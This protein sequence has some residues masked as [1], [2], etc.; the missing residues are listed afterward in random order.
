VIG[1]TFD[2]LMPRYWAGVTFLWDYYLSTRVHTL[3]EPPYVDA[4]RGAS[5]PTHAPAS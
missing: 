1:R 5:E 3:L 2:T 4:P